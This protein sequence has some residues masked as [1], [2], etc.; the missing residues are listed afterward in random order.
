MPIDEKPAAAWDEDDLR[1]MIGRRETPQREFKEMLELGTEG[2]NKIV[3]HDVE[4][5]ANAGG[6]FPFYGIREEEQRD[7]SKLATALVPLPASRREMGPFASRGAGVFAR[8]RAVRRAPALRVRRYARSCTGSAATRSAF[9]SRT[10]RVA[11][12][13]WYNETAIDPGTLRQSAHGVDEEELVALALR[14]KLRRY[15]RTY[16]GA[17]SAM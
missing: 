17:I 14:E 1:E 9:A 5:L 2:L 10:N 7:G 13:D 15:D 8:R 6:G 11:P 12:T 3:E 4:G 16:L